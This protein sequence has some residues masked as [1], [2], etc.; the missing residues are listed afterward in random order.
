[1][2]TCDMVVATKEGIHFGFLLPWSQLNSWNY[3]RHPWL[4]GDELKAVF[5]DYARLRYRLLPYL[6]SCAW[7]AH[8]TG[9]PLLRAMPLEFPNDRETYQL[10]RQYMLGPALLVGAF[11]HR[12][13]L[14]ESDWFDYW[15]GQRVSGP[16]WFEPKI[17]SNRGGPLFVRAG[18]IIPI[19]SNMDYVGQRPDDELTI[20][21]YPGASGR[22][23]LYEDD[24]STY[25]YERG[26]FRTTEICQRT[27]EGQVHVEV[28]EAVGT[29][30]GA[31]QR[32][33]L[34][35]L[36]YG[37][38]KPSRVELDGA[39]LGMEK[40]GQ[41]EFWRWDEA[42]LTVT[43]CLGKRETKEKMALAISS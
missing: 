17:P 12:F 37:L 35:F 14:P 33:K 22:F 23:V 15:T 42:A 18:S 1:M 36:I 21:V 40:E 28:A 34:Q 3:W 30:Q 7:D 19:G 4:Q 10:L 24:G 39:E 5:R 41:K 11:T 27:I 9:I 20:Q 6:Y 26:D 29:F 8:M 25:D 38:Q 16:K 2:T 32:R 13:Y 31:P 43:V